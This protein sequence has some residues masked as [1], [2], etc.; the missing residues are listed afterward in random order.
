MKIDEE[1]LKCR[2]LSMFR[3]ERLISASSTIASEFVLG[4]TG[5]RCD[6][7]IW[8]G[9][10]V[11]VE[12]KS[13][14]DSLVRLADQMGAYRRFF[15]TVIVLCDEVHWPK[16]ERI[17]GP[18]IA[19]YVW[20]TGSQIEFRRRGTRNL[21]ADRQAYV[22][23][24]TVRQLQSC[25]GTKTLDGYSRSQLERRVLADLS[26]DVKSLMTRRFEA[27]YRGTTEAFW[28]AI[29][30]RRISEDHLAHLSRFAAARAGTQLAVDARKSFWRDWSKQAQVVFGSA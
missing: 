14:R 29:A 4:Q 1:G 28:Q 6:L 22:K 19:I 15:D 8:N 20:S 24:L 25:L 16:V 21:A 13:A 10:F 5:C 17:C 23:A 11:G 18:E 12:I 7:A 27:S 26:I 3:K 30:R 9:E 2:I